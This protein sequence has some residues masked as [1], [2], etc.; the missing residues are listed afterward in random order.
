MKPIAFVVPGQRR[1]RQEP[2]D[3]RRTVER[4]DREQVE[5]RENDIHYPE[6][7]HDLSNEA[8]LRVHE[9]LMQAMPEIAART[10]LVAGPAR[11]RAPSR[12]GDGAGG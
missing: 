8:R 10:M 5:H 6:L 12:C 4:R 11:A 7:E 1:H 2:L 9:K 3:E